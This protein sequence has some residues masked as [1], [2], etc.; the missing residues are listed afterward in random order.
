MNEQEYYRFFTEKINE[1]V[2]AKFLYEKIDLATLAAIDHTIKE[3]LCYWQM[4]ADSAGYSLI[5]R[6]MASRLAFKAQ[7]DPDDKTRILLQADNAY[8][9]QLAIK[10]QI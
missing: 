5:V 3:E 10:Y 7:V 9:Y 8:T 2:T 4:R 6:E 1:K